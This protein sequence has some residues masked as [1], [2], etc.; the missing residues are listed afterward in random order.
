M[1]KWKGIMQSGFLEI[2]VNVTYNR[3]SNGVS[4]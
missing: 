1:G 3:S 2:L 4:E